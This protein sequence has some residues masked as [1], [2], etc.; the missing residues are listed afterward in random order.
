MD[1]LGTR[2]KTDCDAYSECTNICNSGC[3]QFAIYASAAY[4]SANRLLVG[5]N[6]SAIDAAALSTVGIESISMGGGSASM[7]TGDNPVSVISLKHKGNL[8]FSI[9]DH[10][11]KADEEIIV[12]DKYIDDKCLSLISHLATA[13][14]NLKRLRIYTTNINSSCHTPS[15]IRAHLAAIKPPGLTVTCNLTSVNFRQKAHDRYIFLGSRL[16]MS[17]TAG[18]G[19]FG[20]L[21]A[22]GDRVNKMSSINIYDLSDSIETLEFELSNNSKFSVPFIPEGLLLQLS[23]PMHLLRLSRVCVHQGAQML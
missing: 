10:H 14:P 3:S 15:V 4:F 17:F 2:S 19:Q 8:N 12:Y 7:N 1:Y 13:S 16:L 6:F 23:N 5:Q 21:N 11:F 18:L 22:H 9:I 20:A